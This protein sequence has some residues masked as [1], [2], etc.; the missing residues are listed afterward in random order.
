MRWD[1]GSKAEKPDIWT[2]TAENLGVLPQPV[3]FI[4]DL[5]T[6]CDRQAIPE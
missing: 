5:Q 1:Y 2:P 3:R 4:H 6:V